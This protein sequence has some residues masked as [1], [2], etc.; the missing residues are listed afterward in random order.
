VRAAAR[1]G[2]GSR[3]PAQDTVPFTLWVVARYLEDYETVVRAC[4][5]VGGDVG[6]TA[7][8]VGGIAGARADGVPVPWRRRR[9]PLPDWLGHRA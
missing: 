6:T 7:A 3:I 2:N 5:A 4:A 8:I 1:P 9:E